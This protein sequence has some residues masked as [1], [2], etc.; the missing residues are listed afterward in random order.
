MTAIDCTETR[1]HL[2]LHAGGDL[3]SPLA[4]VVREHLASCEPCAERMDAALRARRA[5]LTLRGG[6]SE[7]EVLD[8]WPGIRARLAEGGRFAGDR[9]PRSPTAPATPAPVWNLARF[10]LLTGAAA[11]VV[12]ALLVWRP[13][14]A[15]PPGTAPEDGVRMSLG[16]VARPDPTAA[17]PGSSGLRRAGPDDELLRNSAR[18][19]R[20]RG[21]V[22]A[23]QP[24]ASVW[25]LASD[26]QV[27]DDFR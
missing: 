7:P 1:S 24:G 13:W 5:L 15:V 8:L 16:E 20:L 25:S 11:A 18:D 26:E 2:P 19:F 12:L 10:R 17:M 27:T 14:V 4:E 21:R 22:P 23:G 3:E 9:A 6:D